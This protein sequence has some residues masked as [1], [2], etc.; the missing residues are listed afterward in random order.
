MQSASVLEKHRQ[1]LGILYVVF[2]ALMAFA[3]IAVFAAFVLGAL[4]VNDP[5]S[6]VML[7]LGGALAAFLLLLSLPGFIGGIGL[8]RRRPWSKVLTLIVAMPNLASFPVGTA[9]GLYTIWFW[10]Q[11]N[12]ERLFHFRGR[13]PRD[14][15]LGGPGFRRP[16]IS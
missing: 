2:S 12:V 10:V 6:P 4:S 7:G 8:L 11:P 16:L 3:G 5:D 14:S 15:E 9:L 13:E 1:A